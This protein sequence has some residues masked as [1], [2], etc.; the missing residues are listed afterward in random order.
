MDPLHQLD[1]TH[2]EAHDVVCAGAKRRDRY[3]LAAQV[4]SDCPVIVGTYRWP[5]NCYVGRSSSVADTE[6]GYVLAAQWHLQ[7]AGFYPESSIDGLFGNGT[8]N[9]T[10]NFQRTVGLTQSGVV[11]QQ[12]WNVMRDRTDYLYDVNGGTEQAFTAENR[13]NAIFH[14]R[15]NGTGWFVWRPRT[16]QMWG[17]SLYDF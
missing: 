4:P 6:G 17:M 8:Y 11:R 3:A 9:A 16:S 5:N 1:L 7:A 13:T 14:W 15:K 12:T 10:V 2:R